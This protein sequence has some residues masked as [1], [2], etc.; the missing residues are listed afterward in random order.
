MTCFGVIHLEGNQNG[1]TFYSLMIKQK[2]RKAVISY[3]LPHS[4]LE[5]KWQISSYSLSDVLFSHIGLVF[6]QSK[7]S[8]VN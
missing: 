2:S 8:S 6:P 5:S 3:Y 7:K 1:L 4:L